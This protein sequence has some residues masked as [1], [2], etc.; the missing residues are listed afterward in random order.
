MARTVNTLV[1]GAAAMMWAAA[2]SGTITYGTANGS[3][4]ASFQESLSAGASGGFSRDALHPQDYYVSNAYPVAEFGPPVFAN[5]S[6]SAWTWLRSDR[7]YS[8]AWESVFNTPQIGGRA[9]ASMS[10]HVEFTTD[11]GVDFD[12]QCRAYMNSYHDTVSSSLRSGEIEYLNMFS[13]VGAG[14]WAGVL[15][16]GSYV[17]DLSVWSE[18]PFPGTVNDG[19]S[20]YDGGAWWSVSIPAPGAISLIGLAATALVWRRR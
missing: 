4:S 15:L 17:L 6:A 2:A 19:Q 8:T 13:E 5:A 1:F 18:A 9:T 11:A 16:P 7:I 20:R 10:L 14:H 3:A 12:L